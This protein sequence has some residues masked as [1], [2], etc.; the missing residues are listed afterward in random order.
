[1]LA[2]FFSWYITV[3]YITVRGIIVVYLYRS[4]ILLG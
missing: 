3:R 4:C 2:V 1:V